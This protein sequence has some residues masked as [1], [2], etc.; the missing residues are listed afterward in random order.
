MRRFIVGIIVAGVMLG[1][2]G[3]FGDRMRVVQVENELR[4]QLGYP[5]LYE[6]EVDDEPT[7][8]G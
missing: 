4:L 6:E 2:P 3:C 8:L 5:P 1:L 7:L